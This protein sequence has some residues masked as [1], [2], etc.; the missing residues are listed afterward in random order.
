MRGSL[1]DVDLPQL[2]MIRLSRQAPIER[3][4]PEGYV[5]RIATPADDVNLGEMMHVGF[6]RTWDA[7]KVN[8][9]LL[10]H[11]EVPKTFVV[12]KGGAIVAGASYQVK[13]E[14][15]RV[16]WIHWVAAHPDHAGKGLGYVVTRAVI[17]ESL[18]RGNLSE[19]LTTDDERLP[20]IATYLKLGFEPECWHPSH[21]ERWEQVRS[22]L[23]PAESGRFGAQ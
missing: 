12:E 17:V 3:A 18:E 2:K 7:E 13:A 20:A 6:D 19:A 1:V 22:R 23:S 5:L 9:E 15:P 11:P 8:E 16:G 21:E 10:R 4:L 14:T